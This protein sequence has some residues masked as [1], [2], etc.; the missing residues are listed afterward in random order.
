MWQIWRHNRDLRTACFGLLI[1]Y[2]VIASQWFQPWYVLWLLALLAIKP[3]R[4]QFGWV[5]TW[6][7]SGQASYLLAYFILFWLGWPGNQ[8]P[9]Q[10]LYFL[11]IFVPPLIVWAV[12]RP[13]QRPQPTRAGDSSPVPAT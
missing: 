1:W 11:V 12:T 13:R 3:S 10:I 6:A 8:L 2:L 4:D 7:I 5:E 9:G